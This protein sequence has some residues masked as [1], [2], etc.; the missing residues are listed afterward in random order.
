MM[1]RASVGGGQV[2]WKILVI[3]FVAGG[4]AVAFALVPA[5][6]R[7][8]MIA[9]VIALIVGAPL[10]FL[11]IKVFGELP[12]AAQKCWKCPKCGVIRYE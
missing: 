6:Y 4:C 8:H 2:I 1:R 3:V 11:A 7:N 5:A 9:R 10:L 12:S